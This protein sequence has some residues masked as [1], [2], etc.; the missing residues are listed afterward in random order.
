MLRYDVLHHHG[1]KH[2]TFDK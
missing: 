2:K 1:N